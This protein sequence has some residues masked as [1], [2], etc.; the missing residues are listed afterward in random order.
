MLGFLGFQECK[1]DD[2]AYFGNN[3]HDRIAIL[4]DEGIFANEMILPMKKY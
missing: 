1:G 3:L 4:E 2:S